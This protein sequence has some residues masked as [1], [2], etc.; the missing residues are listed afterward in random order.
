MNLIFLSGIKKDNVINNSYDV[1][2]K[3]MFLV[4]NKKTPP[5]HF[6]KLPN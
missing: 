1:T 5:L 4:G 6:I 3:D 2:L